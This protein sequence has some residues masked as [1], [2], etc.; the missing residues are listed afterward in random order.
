MQ[1]FYTTDIQGDLAYFNEVEARHIVQVLRHQVG[2]LLH[3]VDGHGTLFRG[4]IVEARKKSCALSILHRE[5]AYKQRSFVLHVA[6]APP[7]NTGRFEWFL[8]KATELGSDRIIP[9]HCERSE[10]SRLRLERLEKVLLAAMKQSLRATLPQ[11][12][13]LTPFD[14]LLGQPDL[15]TER[16]IA[17]CAEGEKRP[18]GETYRP[19][20]DVIILIGPDGDFSPAEI[21]AAHQRGFR[22]TSLGPS[23]LRT[24]TAALTACTILNYLN[25]TP[26]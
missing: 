4:R 10:R 22:A 13:P 9:L 7:K 11:L 14:R 23:R 3:F 26:A 19:G 17:H 25:Q 8:E 24:E 16:L 20:Q 15:P 6:I 12:Q 1:L 2:D 21:D 18:L 5:S